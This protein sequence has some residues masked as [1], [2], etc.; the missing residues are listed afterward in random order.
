VSNGKLGITDVE[1]SASIVRGLVLIT[2]IQTDKKN[3]YWQFYKSIDYFDSCVFTFRNRLIIFC[4]LMCQHFTLLSLAFQNLRM[5]IS[6]P[7]HNPGMSLRFIWGNFRQ[8]NRNWI[9]LYRSTK[10]L[11]WLQMLE[12]LPQNLHYLN[13]ARKTL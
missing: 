9:W 4:S 5:P 8:I 10:Q 2:K 12:Y 11:R 1:P 3:K 13:F 7:V 6:K